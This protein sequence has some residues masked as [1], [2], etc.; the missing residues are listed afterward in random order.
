MILFAALPVDDK[1][2]K[3]LARM[4]KGVPGARWRPRDNLHMTLCY[5]GDV[6]LDQA[7]VLDDALARN[8][9]P[10]VEMTVSGAGHFGKTDIHSIWT[11]VLPNEQITALRKACRQ[12][13]REAGINLEARKYVPHITMAYLKAD[14]PL[15]RIISFEERMARF[16]AGPQLCDQIILYSSEPKKRGANLYVP[17]AS[18]P[19]LG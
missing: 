18:Y 8:P 14:A 1:L 13:A 10:P 19:L 7:E 12:A 4:S 16:T 11:R 9:L 5:F 3:D 17:Q 15:E 6:T 2:A